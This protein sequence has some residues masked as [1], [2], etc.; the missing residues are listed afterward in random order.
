MFALLWAHDFAPRVRRDRGKIRPQP[1][2]GDA[3]PLVDQPVQGMLP[4]MPVLPLWGDSD[5]DGGWHDEA[6][7]RDPYWRSDLWYRA[8]RKLPPVRA[9]IRTGPLEC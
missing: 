3:V 8:T 6:A 5:P 7:G 9:H 2:Q 4:W 1:G